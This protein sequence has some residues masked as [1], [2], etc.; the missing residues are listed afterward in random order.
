[1]CRITGLWDFK[2][3]NPNQLQE[4]VTMMKNTMIHGGPDDSGAYVDYNVGLALG[5]RRLSII[6]LTKTGQQPM[7]HPSDRWVICY[8]GEVYNFKEVKAELIAMGEIFKSTS[9][10]EVILHAWAKWG[11]KCLEK[12]RGM[13]A[14]AIWD[15]Q[16]QQ[17]TIVR[18]RMGVKP[19][20]YYHHN[21]IFMFASEL[22]AFHQHP[23]FQKELNQDAVA[24]F[25]TYGYVQGE[26]AIFKHVYK[27]SPGTLLVINHKQQIE[28]STYWSLPQE[29]RPSSFNESDFLESLHEELKI[30]FNLRMVSD[31]PVGVFLSGGVDSSLLASILQSSAV[32]KI[33]TFT[34]GFDDPRYD[35]SEPAKNIASYLGTNHHALTCS[36]K[37]AL[38]II[39][40]LPD[41]YDEPFGD[42]SAIPTYLVSSLASDYVKVVLSADGGDEQ[43]AGYNRYKIFDFLNK[44]EKIPFTKQALKMANRMGCFKLMGMLNKDWTHFSH[45]VN[46]TQS[47]LSATSLPEKIAVMASPFQKNE[48]VT[49]PPIVFSSGI[50]QSGAFPIWDMASYLPD[51]ILTKVDRATMAVSI[52]GRE[53]FL[54]HKLIE[55]S[56]ECPYEFKIKDGYQ[57][58]PLRKILSNYLPEHLTNQPK[59]GFGV[60]LF[61]WLENELF[62]EVVSTIN[63][64]DLELVECI[65]SDVLNE[66]VNNYKNNSHAEHPLKI[67]YLYVFFC[68]YN[69]WMS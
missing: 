25:M 9:D 62:D 57:K 35:E 42:T 13:F 8:N 24:S 59:K 60:P 50:N 1:M 7:T 68:W 46:K 2:N 40:K 19:L 18:D 41:V 4:Q 22:K 56:F 29:S 61:E 52:E 36:L 67:W 10:T 48:Y 69:R 43:Y 17:L 30:S 44:V 16:E 33:N 58:Y 31:V 23:L 55:K 6:D 49:N 12:F 64:A 21:N 5:H 53:P 20:Y 45:R 54:D 3:Q 32:N 39:P 63:S 65:R 27:L 66:L 51:D 11:K 47:I 14:F 38:D 15:K 28:H 34:I 37:E 26:S